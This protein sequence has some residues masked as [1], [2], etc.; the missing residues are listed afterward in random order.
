M[1][2]ASFVKCVCVFYLLILYYQT[3]K[4]TICMTF[5][6]QRQMEGLRW[7]FSL[8]SLVSC[9]MLRCAVQHVSLA[10]PPCSSYT[11]HI[12]NFHK[13]KKKHQQIDIASPEMPALFREENA[14][15]GSLTW[16]NKAPS[17][18]TNRRPL[19]LHQAWRAP[20]FFPTPSSL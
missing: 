13:R 3:L 1:S 9:D 15:A 16:A 5:H 14:H 6:H 18:A 17:M 2:Q 12:N 20:L 19:P 4:K 11:H 8:V 7:I 10:T